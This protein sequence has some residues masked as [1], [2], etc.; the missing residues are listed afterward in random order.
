MSNICQIKNKY[1]PN[2]LNSWYLSS[3]SPFLTLAKPMYIL[4]LQVK[5]KKF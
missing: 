5:D 2:K 4:N 1:I 3:F